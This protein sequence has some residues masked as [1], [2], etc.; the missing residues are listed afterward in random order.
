MDLETQIR[1]MLQL[2]TAASA[3]IAAYYSLLAKKEAKSTND[4][5]NHTQPGQE[6]LYDLVAKTH[7]RL[8]VVEDRQQL[9]QDIIMS[10]PCIREAEDCDRAEGETG[11]QP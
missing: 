1:P 10:R 8:I 9:F 2:I 11:A 4:A 3:A 7:S 6:R 5:V